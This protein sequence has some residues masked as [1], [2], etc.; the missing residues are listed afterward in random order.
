L[1][2]VVSKPFAGK[3]D[4]G[5]ADR[6]RALIPRL[7]VIVRRLDLFAHQLSAFAPYL[8]HP[9]ANCR[10]IVSSTRARQCFLPGFGVDI[11]K[12]RRL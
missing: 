5:P 3:P 12:R 6:H 9:F 1:P 4:L 8:L 10:K 2:A 7:T 11:L